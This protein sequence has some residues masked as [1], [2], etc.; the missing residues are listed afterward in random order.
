MVLISPPPRTSPAPRKRAFRQQ[1]VQA[2]RGTASGA[3]FLALR[4]AILDC[5]LPPGTPMIEKDLCARF[6]VSRTPVREALI[7][8]AEE[9]LVMVYP[10]SGTYVAPIP[11]ASLPEAVI[12]RKA[13]EHAAL[14]HALAAH[15][16]EGLEALATLLAEQQACA[17]RADRD[18]FHAAD[19]AFHEA[20]AQM[21][22][23]PGLWRVAQQA[24]A[25]IDRCRRLTLPQKGRMDVVI[26]EHRA[27]YT[28]LAGKE[29]AV[30]HAALEAHLSAVLPDAQT[31]Q[32]HYPGY[33]V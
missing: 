2:P 22:H 1:P 13:L 33:F 3:I 27:I 19:E 5:S 23:A 14:S 7:R 11:L 15:T 18:A 29:A 9:K 17:E 30:A 25:Q 26:A 32:L 12:I 31:L 16:P 8:L 4:K 28:A 21:A 6:E 24:K 10:Q 20:I